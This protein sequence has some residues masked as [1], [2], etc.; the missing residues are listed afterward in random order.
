MAIY[1]LLLV[2]FWNRIKKAITFWTYLADSICFGEIKKYNSSFG[3][4]HEVANY[5]EY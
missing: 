1:G 5:I 4:R 2:L 3:K